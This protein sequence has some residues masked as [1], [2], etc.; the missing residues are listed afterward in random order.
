MGFYSPHPAETV[1]MTSGDN[2]F[3]NT[4]GI[5]ELPD[6]ITPED[7][8]LSCIRDRSILYDSFDIGVECYS[9][10]E[11]NRELKRHELLFVFIY[12]NKTGKELEDFEV[13]YK[14]T[15]GRP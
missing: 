8:R 14:N 3:S 7:F 15:P 11:K 4:N 5:N 6:S 9:E 12:R 1:M 10:L 2:F 13:T